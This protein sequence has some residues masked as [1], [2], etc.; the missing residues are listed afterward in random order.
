M[1]QFCF[2]ELLMIQ[3]SNSAFTV[4]KNNIIRARVT[5]QGTRPLLQHKFG[6]DSIPL[7]AQEK[8]GKAGND[9]EEWKKTCMLTKQR[10]LYIP[11]YYVFACIRDGSKNTKKG[12]GSI[13]KNVAATLQIED[14]VILLDRFAPDEKNLVLNDYEADVYI[15]CCGVR[16]P[17]TKGRNVRYRLASSPGW[18]CSF[19]IFW[20]KTLVSREQMKA[21]IHDAATL[22]GL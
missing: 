3:S 6:P 18:K 16:N 20:D 8:T 14:T 7:E 4:K 13:Q 1:E 12:K 21:S 17:S 2:G 19:T 9:P 22:C 10:Q 11:G 5:I 15:D